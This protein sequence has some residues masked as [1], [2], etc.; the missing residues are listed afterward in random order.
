MEENNIFIA[1]DDAL[2]YFVGS[3]HKKII[4]LLKNYLGPSI[5]YLGIL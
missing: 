5:K 2:G 1:G 3:M 4:K